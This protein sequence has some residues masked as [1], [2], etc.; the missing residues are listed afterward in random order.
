MDSLKPEVPYGRRLIPTL[1]DEIA[2]NNPRKVFA[3]IP[4]SFDLSEGYVDVTYDTL[5]KAINRAAAFLDGKFGKSTTSE[6]LAYLGL[7]DIR[8]FVLI[9]AACKTGYQVSHSVRALTEADIHQSCSSLHHE[10]ASK[11]S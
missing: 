9:C 3:S 2:Q 1:I 11:D 5:S 6:I 10:T 4:R 7:F 8:Y